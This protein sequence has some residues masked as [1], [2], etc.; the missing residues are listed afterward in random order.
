MGP[1]TLAPVDSPVRADRLSATDLIP[2]QA[3]EVREGRRVIEFGSTEQ[4]VK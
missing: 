2:L 3:G 1:I 4:L